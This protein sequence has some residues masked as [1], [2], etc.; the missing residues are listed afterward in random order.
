[1][2]DRDRALPEHPNLEHLK[3]AAKKRLRE[4]RTVHPRAKLADAQLQLARE[5]SFASWRKLR[6]HVMIAVPAS[7]HID[8]A[9]KV[10]AFLNA[11]VS[12]I[13]SDPREGAL[14]QAEAILLSEPAV[15]T[16]DFLAA[17]V[18]G[19]AKTVFR[20]LKDDPAAATRSAGPRNWVPL[21]YLCYSRYLRLKPRRESAFVKTAKLLVD[22]GAD[23]NSL[24]EHEGFNETALYGAAGVANAPKLTELLLSKGADPDDC[25]PA[26]RGTESLYH[27]CEHSDNRCLKLILQAGPRK[28]NITHCL[29]RKLDFEDIEGVRL[30]L[31]YGADPDARLLHAVRRGR[32]ARIIELLIQRGAK[33]NRVAQDG[34]TAL[35]LARRLGQKKIVQSLQRHGATETSED[36]REEFLAACAG[37]NQRLARELLKQQSDLIQQL[38][39]DEMRIIADA[40]AAGHIAPLKLML[41]LGFDINAKGDW[42]GS[43]LQQAIAR[44]S[45]AIVEYLIERGASLTLKNDYGGDALGAAI[46]FGLESGKSAKSLKVI[47]MIAPLMP[48]P[49]VARRI[50]WAQENHWPELV[51][52]LTKASAR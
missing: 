46:H 18:L 40:A 52:I 24:F 27:A 45:L 38:K 32:S 23:V 11:A 15:A 41:K 1:M 44:G 5:Y 25:Q 37:G 51:Q 33:V 10:T 2:S 34:M 29:G 21:L 26:G 9:E 48:G 13:G 20:F 49:S 35:R 16:A 28:Q 14:H 8:V 19:E 4:L 30:M 3:K 47:K 7:S 50:G 31:D 36:H 17:C 39:P 43:V 22:H 12:P 6:N 42:E